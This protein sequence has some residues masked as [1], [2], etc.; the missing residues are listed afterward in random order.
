[1]NITRLLAPA[2]LGAA[3][4]GAL[5]AAAAAQATDYDGA[6]ALGLSLRRL[7]TT[8]RVLMIGAHPDDE[9][10]QLLAALALGHG[11]DVAYLSLTRGEGGQNGIG[12]EL[13]EALG[14]L[15]T[16]E[17]L[18]ARRV[19]GASQFFTRAYDFGFSKNADEAFRH[20]PR[21]SVLKD[22]VQTIRG[23]RPD[24][25]IAVFSGTPADGHGQHQVSAILAREAF[26]AAADPSRYPE[27]LAAGL[28]PWRTARFYRSQRGSSEGSTVRVA[29]GDLDPLLG[30]S[31]FQLAMAS[32]SRHRSQDMG[33][34]EPAGPRWGYLVRVVPAAQGSEPSIFAGTDSAPSL[35]AERAGLAGAAAALREYEALADRVRREANPLYPDTLVPD[36]ARALGLLARA[37]AEAARAGDAGRDLRFRL[38]A[39]TEDARA[40]LMRAA[41]LRLDAVSAAERLVPGQ[42]VDVEVS[43]WNGGGRP[44]ELASLAPSLPAGWTAEAV[45]AMPSGP[46]AAGALVTRRFRVRLPADVPVTEPYFLRRARRGD[47]YAWPSDPA[48]AGLPFAADP[49]RAAASVRVGGA[50][51]PL[52]QVASFRD[53]D[54]RQG[55]LRR[56]VLV[57][58]A[59]SVRLDPAAR[60]LPTSNDGRGVPL[61]VSVEAQDP[62][63][64]AGTLRLRLPAGW[65]AEPESVAVRFAGAG[66]SRTVDFAVHPAST[67]AA[68]DY[69]VSAVL[70]AAD[71]RRYGRGFEMIDYPHVRPRPLYHDA[72]ATLRAADVRVPA[73]LRVAYVT[74]AGEAGPGVLAQ[75][76]IVPDLLDA[77]ALAGADLSRYDVIVTGSRAYEVRPDLRA[78]N[79]R[80][81]EYVRN[82]GTFVVQY[83]KF[84]QVPGQYTPFPMT[85]A[86]PADRVTDEASP[87]RLTAPQSPVL[88]TP[89]RI[90]EADFQGWNQDRALYVPH[91]FDPAYAPVVETADPGEPP[92]PGSLLIARYGRGTYVYTGLAFF[93]QLPEGVPGAWRLFANLLALGA[94]GGAAAR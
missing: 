91:T 19:E 64:S 71:G 13:G 31:Y 33:R 41:G 68:G 37:D 84:D 6:A 35:S 53:V 16:E 60:V 23:Y 40:A 17:L 8:G 3:L 36:L 25:V 51:L 86:R 29:L 93:R 62:R 76:G 10:T 73:G 66:E 94:R 15:R 65:R 49:L 75:V 90:T 70:D 7:G 55:E 52:E 26:D 27:Q 21:D 43:L 89:N 81:L 50:D 38:A 5:P 9:D 14:L 11:A 2:V 54:P 85:F 24:I 61:R 79:D 58:P 80:L 67:L 32:R 30:R 63:G 46:V 45:D 82:G 77:A 12:P 22:V 78:H 48:V 69:S 88:S 42:T 87:V 72:T 34:P 20:W 83:Y 59:L 74:G 18:A 47:L 57:V 56:P 4:L 39:E 28:R 92:L 44:V 1:M